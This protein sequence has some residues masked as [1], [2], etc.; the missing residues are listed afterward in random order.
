MLP[1]WSPT[2]VSAAKLKRRPPLTTFAQRWMKTTFSSI[3]GPSPDDCDWSRERLS[4]RGPRMPWMSRRWGRWDCGAEEGAGAAATGAAA[5]GAAATGAGATGA[6][7]TGAASTGVAAGSAV[8]AVSLLMCFGSEYK[9]G[10]A[11]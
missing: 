2:T 4:R 5:T 7:V 1:F 8:G 10:L 9:A 6:G 11:G 3:D